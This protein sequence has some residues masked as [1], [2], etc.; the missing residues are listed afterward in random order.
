MSTPN[1]ANAATTQQ[2][3]EAL[4]Q[5]PGADA[6]VSRAV[7]EVLVRGSVDKARVT[8][9]LVEVLIPA[10]APEDPS[11][12]GSSKGIA[13]RQFVE[14]LTRN[15]TPDMAR[16]SRQFTEVLI[17][18]TGGALPRATRQ[19]VEVLVPVGTIG[20]PDSLK[21]QTTRQFAEVLVR[22]NSGVAM[23]SR[24]LM[25]VLVRTDDGEDRAHASR[26][27]IE[28]LRG[29][30][31]GVSSARAFTDRQFY[32]TL[33]SN[34]DA[35]AFVN[36]HFAE[37]LIRRSSGQAETTRSM[38]EV[39]VP[40]DGFG[41]E[42]VCS[43]WIDVGSDLTALIEGLENGIEYTIEVR[44]LNGDII[45]EISVITGIPHP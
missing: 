13:S 17:Q 38:V 35:S 11:S 6:H 16:A 27:F 7:L 2:F 43:P 29:P 10:A 37:A 33:I 31:T 19:F 20:T 34:R 26:Q 1:P 14:I 32:E 42:T 44:A 28:V 15:A 8:T 25:E 36:L 23:A 3:V 41:P 40:F 4:L 24:Q 18:S 5:G 9:N 45:G 39:L 22:S 12:P 30:L 21:G